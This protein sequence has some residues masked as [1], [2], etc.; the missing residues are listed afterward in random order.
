MNIKL[1]FKEKHA[2]T[3]IEVLL[4]V[5]ISS[6]IVL[7]LAIT[8]WRGSDTWKRTKNLTKLSNDLCFALDI[9]EMDLNNAI[10]LPS[11]LNSESFLISEDGKKISF[12]TLKRLKYQKVPHIYKVSYRLLKDTSDLFLLERADLKIENFNKVFYEFSNL[13]YR[14]L[15]SN[16]SQNDLE[17]NGF[18]FGE[19]VKLCQA[20]T[21]D[22]DKD[23]LG[24]I[25][26]MQKEQKEIIFPC[27]NIYVCTQP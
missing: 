20:Q 6:V 11:E 18:V 13:E 8:F 19:I 21:E 15:I 22:G 3:L 17:F 1:T 12:F 7:A 5:S 16:L 26:L 14:R 9:L 25:R 4:A 24:S 27:K 10:K 2:F 23:Y